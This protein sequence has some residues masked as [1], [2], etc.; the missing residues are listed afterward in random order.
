MSKMPFAKK[1]LGEKMTKFT[2]TMRR[3]ALER[4]REASR[5]EDRP[6]SEILTELVNEKYPE[7]WHIGYM[8]REARVRG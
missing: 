6:M 5:R 2:T 7:P 4:L 8:S 1:P 3:D